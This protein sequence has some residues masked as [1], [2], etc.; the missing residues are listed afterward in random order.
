MIDFMSKMLGS[1]TGTSK[2]DDKLDERPDL[3]NNLVYSFR[4]SSYELPEIAFKKFIPDIP[5]PQ[6]KQKNEEFWR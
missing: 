5:V 6:L 4:M 2:C 1:S 3:R